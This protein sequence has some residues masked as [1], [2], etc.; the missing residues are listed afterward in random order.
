[1]SFK[2]Q[3]IKALFMALVREAGG[4]D[5]AGMV[6]GISHQRVS[7]LQL[8]NN[9]DMPTLMHIVMLEH[10]VGQAIVT[11]ALAK[12]VDALARKHADPVIEA[13]EAVEAMSGVLTACVAGAEPKATLAAVNRARK[14]LDDVTAAITANDAA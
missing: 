5:A 7:Q 8:L 11:G 14:E 2:P 4:V 12:S 1:M 13:A 10:A 6:L 9:A 3:Q